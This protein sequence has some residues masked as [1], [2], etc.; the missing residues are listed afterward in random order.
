MEIRR[1]SIIAASLVTGLIFSNHVV[2]GVITAGTVDPASP[3][4]GFASVPFV[5]SLSPNNDN[6]DDLNSGNNVDIV[7]KVFDTPEVID[8]VF[9]VT[10]SGGVTE[11]R[12]SET[13]DNNTIA[14]WASYQMFL[15]FGTGAAFV[16]SGAGDGLDFDAPPDNDPA[17]TSIPFASV[18]RPNEDTLVFFNGIHD[19][20]ARTYEFRIDVPDDLPNGSFTLRQ[21]PILVPEPSSFVVALLALAGMSWLRRRR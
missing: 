15:G 5:I 4:L 6:S 14:P 13:V 17:P 12:V 2:A 10:T 1:R 16:L 18:D 7:T 21:V 9:D 8:I 11:Y 20:G 19:S 3:G